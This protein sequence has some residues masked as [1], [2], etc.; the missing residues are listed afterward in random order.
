[1][2]MNGWSVLQRRVVELG[3]GRDWEC[4]VEPKDFFQKITSV[5]MGCPRCSKSM[6]IERVY[7][8]VNQV[9]SVGY[10]C[11]SCGYEETRPPTSSGFD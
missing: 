7:F 6:A 8:A 9:A 5:E 10:K 4:C 3:C 2:L 11:L 1:M